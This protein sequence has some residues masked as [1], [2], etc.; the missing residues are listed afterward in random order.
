MVFHFYQIL[1]YTIYLNQGYFLWWFLLK[2]CPP[3]AHRIWEYGLRSIYIYYNISLWYRL[4][5]ADSL[6][7]TLLNILFSYSFLLLFCSSLLF[8]SFSSSLFDLFRSSSQSQFRNHGCNFLSQNYVCRELCRISFPLEASK[9]S[10]NHQTLH[11]AHDYPNKLSLITSTY[12]YWNL[13]YFL[14]I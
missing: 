2:Y 14:G 12:Y 11:K 6:E 4:F 9:S 5:S 1:P 3:M 10:I 8:F 13:I 7:Q